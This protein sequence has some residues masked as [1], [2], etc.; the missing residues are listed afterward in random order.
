M[1]PVA[2]ED[3]RVVL[4]DLAADDDFLA[5]ERFLLGIDL[6]DGPAV[7]TVR[8]SHLDGADI[9][10]SDAVGG[11]ARGFG[12]FQSSESDVVELTLEGLALEARHV[13]GTDDMGRGALLD[14]RLRHRGPL[15]AGGGLEPQIGVG[16]G[17][18]GFQHRSLQVA[19]RGGRGRGGKGEADGEQA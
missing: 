17:V 11:V 7:R 14:R 9:E 3:G 1:D 13:D 19:G 2:V 6:R 10:R 4:D 16:P 8:L 5:L 12:A 15:F 18:D